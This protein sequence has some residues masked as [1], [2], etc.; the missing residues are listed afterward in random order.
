MDSEAYKKFLLSVIPSAKLASGGRNINCRCFFCPDSADPSHKH[1]YI[2]IPQSNDEPSLYYC[3]LCHS[4]GV[5]THNTLIKWHIYDENIA[6]DLINHN[7]K[8]SSV[9]SNG[10][11]YDRKIYN[12]RNTYI[13]DDEVTR[14]KLKYINDRLGTNLSFQ[15]TLDLK[16][17][18]NIYDILNCNRI[19][20]LTRDKRIVDQLDEYFMG[21]LSIDN[22][23]C[24]MRRICESGIV[25][26]SI[27]KRYINYKIYDKFSTTERFY[28][29]PTSINL[30][31]LEPIKIHVAEGPFD[32]LSVYLNLRNKEPGIYTSIAGSNYIGQIMYFLQTFTLP[33]F[34]E[35]H[36]YPDNDQYGSDRNMRNI[37][38]SLAMFNFPLYIHRNA[39][40]GEKDF[41]VHYNRINEQITRL[42]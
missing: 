36:L 23:F 21:F 13:R 25:N 14:I 3:H 20:S 22:A 12:I 26:K 40:P 27:D 34:I 5:M 41:G 29:V 8:C 6:L 2:S 32:I 19:Q 31:S 16:I 24:N 39:S 7:K 28:T 15:D 42:N 18:L 33:P 1:M 11:Y 4:S 30:D 17:V 38:D 37:N 9:K 10:K 35:I